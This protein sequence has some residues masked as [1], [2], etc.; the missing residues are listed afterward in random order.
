MGKFE[1][2]SKVA[3]PVFKSFIEN[4]LFK[5]EFDE[6]KIPKIITV[7]NFGYSDYTL[8]L[9]NSMKKCND[10]QIID[11]FVCICFDE[12]CYISIRRNMETASNECEYSRTG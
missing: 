4:S 1:T 3:L 5:E 8:N 6:F 12:I 11:N 9:Y 2:G 10:K 7:C